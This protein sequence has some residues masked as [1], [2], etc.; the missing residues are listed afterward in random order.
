[1]ARGRDS[2]HSAR[3]L[4]GLWPSL[5]FL[6]SAESQGGVDLPPAR[7][8]S[9]SVDPQRLESG[10]PGN[11]GAPNPRAAAVMVPVGG[12]AHAGPSRQPSPLRTS[13]PGPFQSV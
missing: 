10:V 12:R 6:V 2:P 7:V 13:L 8:L 5:P 11:H 1:M 4:P 9:V 3:E